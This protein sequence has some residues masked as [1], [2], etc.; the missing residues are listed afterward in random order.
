MLTEKRPR[1]MDILE[2]P[3]IKEVHRKY[4]GITDEMLQEEL[5]EHG[6]FIRYILK[7]HE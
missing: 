7:S 6:M 4:D 3:L 2:H 1:S 5:S